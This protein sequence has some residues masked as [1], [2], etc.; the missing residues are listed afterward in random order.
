MLGSL[1]D[2][3]WMVLGHMTARGECG[4]SFITVHFSTL[5]TAYYSKSIFRNASAV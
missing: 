5:D 3:V 4:L 2:R 1:G